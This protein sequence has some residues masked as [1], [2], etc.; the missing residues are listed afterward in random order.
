MRELLSLKHILVF[1]LPLIF[2]T[3][4]HQISHTILHAFLARLA[5]PTVTLAAFSIAF[6]FCVTLGTINQ[7]SVQSGIS[8]IRAGS[9]SSAEVLE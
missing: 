4:L 9:E 3:E 5:D 7:I 6:A 8:F 1:F 2:V